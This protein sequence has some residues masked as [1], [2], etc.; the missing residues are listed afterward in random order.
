MRRGRTSPHRTER[1]DLD[2]LGTPTCMLEKTTVGASRH[3]KHI[4][5]LQRIKSSRILRIFHVLQL[6]KGRVD[7]RAI[8]VQFMDCF[9]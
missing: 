9:T 2:S 1:L 8:V 6:H 4:P 7:A 3:A 5:P